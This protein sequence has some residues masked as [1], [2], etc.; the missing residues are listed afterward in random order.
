MVGFQKLLAVT[1]RLAVFCFFPFSFPLNTRAQ[2]LAPFFLRTWEQAA[3]GIRLGICRIIR[4]YL[5]HLALSLKLTEPAA[6]GAAL[7]LVAEGPGESLT[8]WR[9]TLRHT[10][11]LARQCQCGVTEAGLQPRGVQATGRQAAQST[12]LLFVG[13]SPGRWYRQ[14]FLLCFI[15]H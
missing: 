14:L 10:G 13:C 1:T 4:L 11:G 9:D 5:V 3:V 6:S 2:H 8:R 15:F 12:S 7:C